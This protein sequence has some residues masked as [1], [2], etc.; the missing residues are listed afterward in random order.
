[1]EK[2]SRRSAIRAATAGA[3]TV[4]TA[5]LGGTA[6][7]DEP[8]APKLWTLEGN[9]KVHPLFIYRYYLELL[10]GQKCAL[11]GSDHGREPDQLARLKLPVRVR[12]RG[13]LGTEYNSRG[14]KENPSQFPE[15]WIV[16]MNV[17]EVKVLNY[18]PPP[19]A[20]PRAAPD[21]GG[22]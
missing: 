10:D 11:Y 7:G 17:Q 8:K 4:G 2:V 12:V 21:R 19:S 15:G 6:A 18:L 20:E 1:M 14:T 16:Y 5:V 22:M 3:V 13:V 9:L